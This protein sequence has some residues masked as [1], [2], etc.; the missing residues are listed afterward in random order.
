MASA[1]HVST[2]G[3]LDEAAFQNFAPLLAD[4]Q[5]YAANSGYRFQ[6]SSFRG[7]SHSGPSLA[8]GDS[9]PR[10]K[11]KIKAAPAVDEFTARLRAEE[12]GLI[13]EVEFAHTIVMTESVR[14]VMMT[15]CQALDMLPPTPRPT[16]IDDND[17]AY[18]DVTAPLP[19]IAQ[20]LHN[21]QSQRMRDSTS[22]HDE[23]QRRALTAAFIVDF[24]SEAGMKMPPMPQ[25]QQSMLREFAERTN[26]YAQE[27]PNADQPRH[28]IE[29]FM[30][31][32]GVSS[33][34]L[35]LNK[36]AKHWWTMLEKQPNSQSP[37]RFRN[38]LED[39]GVGS[40]GQMLKQEAQQWWTAAGTFVAARTSAVKSASL[41]NQGESQS[42]STA[43]W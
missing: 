10:L 40:S 24:A 42:W 33:A 35:L 39:L 38:M 4:C 9:N 12:P 2:S 28:S 20:R 15:M 32:L 11:A 41:T 21:Y 1:N 30:D 16:S 19:L 14:N 13:R 22:G 6:I 27:R 17:C 25:T 34:G 8:A 31:D 23:L 3:V 29:R 36:E 43:W 18:E 26:E 37:N 7:V 5:S